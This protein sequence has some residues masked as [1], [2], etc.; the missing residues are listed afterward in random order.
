MMRAYN[1]LIVELPEV[2]FSLIGSD[3]KQIK[4]NPKYYLYRLYIEPNN[5]F[6]KIFRSTRISKG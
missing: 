3:R 2:A 1:E 4:S 6:T 5:I